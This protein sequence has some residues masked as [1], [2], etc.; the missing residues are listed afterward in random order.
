MWWATGNGSANPNRV[1]YSEVGDADSTL[2][3]ENVDEYDGSYITNLSSSGNYLFAHKPNAVWIVVLRTESNQD[4][5]NPEYAGEPY[6]IYKSQ[7]EEGAIGR[8]ALASTGLGDFYAGHNGAYH[9]AN[10]QASLISEPVEHYWADSMINKNEIIVEEHNRRVYFSYTTKGSSYNDRT[11]VYDIDLNMW[12]KYHIGINFLQAKGSLP[13]ID[14]VYIGSPQPTEES[15]VLVLGGELRDTG[16]HIDGKWRSGWTAMDKPW[17]T[18][19]LFRFQLTLMGDDA[20]NA[21]LAT[22]LDFGSTATEVDTMNLAV[23]NWAQIDSAFTKGLFGEWVQF[24][25]QSDSADSF[26]LREFDV[27][28]FEKTS[29]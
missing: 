22:Y 5:D 11:L 7:A 23:S 9:F 16:Q 28:F 4:V 8:H 29:R 19:D 2:G 20:A 12:W 17:V 21:I 15:Q 24:E 1:W 27:M 13:S 10:G 26:M 18:K 3:W 14:S 6:H 25:V